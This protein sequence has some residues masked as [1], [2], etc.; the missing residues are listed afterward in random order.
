MSTQ[1]ITETIR[2]SR[3]RNLRRYR[4]DPGSFLN[5][6]PARLLGR[7][8]IDR[9]SGSR[10]SCGLAPCA[11]SYLIS[12]DVP[13]ERLVEAAAALYLDK[14]NISITARGRGATGFTGC[15]DYDFALAQA[16]DRDLDLYLSVFRR[17]QI[18][19]VGICCF[20]DRQLAEAGLLECQKL[21]IHGLARSQSRVVAEQMRLGGLVVE[22]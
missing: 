8:P 17:G 12:E 18:V 10:S 9:A 14:P 19:A 1:M 4:L 16:R 7:A 5:P 2:T 13:L 11:F 20:E 3:S 6:E 15:I 21:F 22:R